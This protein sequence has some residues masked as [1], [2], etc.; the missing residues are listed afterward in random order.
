[1][2][3]VDRGKASLAGDGLSRFNRLNYLKQLLPVRYSLPFVSNHT[4]Q[5]S[6]NIPNLRLPKCSLKLP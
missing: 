5:T 1:M 2:N 3:L 6:K 4:N